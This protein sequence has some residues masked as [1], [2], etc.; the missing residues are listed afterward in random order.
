MEER[1]QNPDKLLALRRCFFT[2]PSL[3]PCSFPIVQKPHAIVN[4]VRICLHVPAV[5]MFV[6]ASP[7]PRPPPFDDALSQTGGMHAIVPA[8]GQVRNS[9]LVGNGAAV[10]RRISTPLL[11]Q[12]ARICE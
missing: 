7:S 1:L 9:A 4:G 6:V 2:P 11:R 8:T 3:R 5:Q 12:C 10:R